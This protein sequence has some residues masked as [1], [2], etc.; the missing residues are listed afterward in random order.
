MPCCECAICSPT[1]RFQQYHRYSGEISVICSGST[2]KCVKLVHATVDAAA[3]DVPA[4]GRCSAGRVDEPSCCTL[5]TRWRNW[6]ALALSR[7]ASSE[8]MV[9]RGTA[10]VSTLT[11]S[12]VF[13]CLS[14]SS[15][16][17]FAASQ[18][19]TK[20]MREASS[21]YIPLNPAIAESTRHRPWKFPMMEP[22]MSTG[23]DPTFF[24]PV[25]NMMS[26]AAIASTGSDGELTY[27]VASLDMRLTIR[28][29]RS[30][31]LSMKSF[32]SPKRAPPP[33]C[34]GTRPRASREAMTLK[35][36]A[37]LSAEKFSLP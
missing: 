25:H 12:D 26:E 27:M 10:R 17:R 6:S 2:S 23:F 35:H 3:A 34:T 1:P 7:L 5:S 15:S 24:A 21:P 16:L 20:A 33:S 30:T 4:G 28:M 9:S 31:V 18:A 32:C 8:R 37:V 29:C 19:T 13:C 36:C 22:Y 14:A 11:C